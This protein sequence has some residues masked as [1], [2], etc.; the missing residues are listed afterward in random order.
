MSPTYTDDRGA[1]VEA[2]ASA[3]LELMWVLHFLESG[4]EH[5]GAFASL[6]PL[7]QRFGAELTRLRSDGLAQNSTELV[8]LAHSSGTLLDLDLERFFARIEDTAG[9]RSPVPSLLSE[10]PAE[11]EIVR[12]RLDR[13]RTERSVRESYIALLSQVWSAVR[14]EWEDEGRPAAIAEAQRWSRALA[15]GAAYKDLLG[16]SRLWIGRPE[17]D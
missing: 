1:V 3:P 10:R 8:V 4:H 9:N 13:L 7:R 14:D 6:E 15:D 12:V 17:M 2:R 16:L 11:R 5:E